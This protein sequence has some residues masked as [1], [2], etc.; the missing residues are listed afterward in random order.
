LAHQFHVSPLKI[1]AA[2]SSNTEKNLSGGTSAED[3]FATETRNFSA[4]V[5]ANIFA[6]LQKSM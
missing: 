5:F 2:V 4:D 3:S 6:I 1:F